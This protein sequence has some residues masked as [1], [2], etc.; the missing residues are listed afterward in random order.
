MSD[1][2]ARLCGDGG[3]KFQ[4]YVMPI[5]K[6]MLANRDNM[7]RIAYLMATYRHY[8]SYRVDDKGVSFEIF[9]PQITADD[10]SRINNADPAYALSIATFSM[11]DLFEYPQ[12]VDL[13]LYLA[14]QIK[15][16]GAMMVLESIIKK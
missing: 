16:H 14:K 1:Q 5:V 12:F 4:V 11:I 3:S 2:I 6:Q 13:Y 15:E 10:M 7:I 8:L 9:E